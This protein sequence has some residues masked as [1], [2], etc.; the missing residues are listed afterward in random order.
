MTSSGAVPSAISSQWEQCD[1]C[2]A[3][4]DARQR[5]CVGCGARRPQADDPVAS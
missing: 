3:P 2:Q 1:H 4:L 5:Y